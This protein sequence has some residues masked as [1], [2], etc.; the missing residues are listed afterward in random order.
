M[1]NKLNNGAEISRSTN[2]LNSIIM[3][4]IIILAVFLAALTAGNA[5][6]QGQG[7]F[8]VRAG[9][10]STNMILRGNGVSVKANK[11]TGFQ[12]G[13]VT[14]NEPPENKRIFTQ[15]GFLFVSQKCSFDESFLGSTNGTISLS[16]LRMPFN[17]IFKVDLSS[18]KLLGYG[19]GILGLALAG[20][21]TSEER[22]G[23][24]IEQKI[25][26]GGPI[27]R[28]EIGFNLGAGLQFGNFQATVEYNI[29]LNYGVLFN[30]TNGVSMFN[31]GFLFN[32]TYF[33][34]K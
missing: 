34:G 25:K 12:I 31:N 14:E 29:N 18:L 10:N 9:L 2:I 20:K 32:L 7:T 19:G 30:D 5:Q 28:L 6:G 21:T 11:E 24:K 22:G 13:V 15:G 1:S 4:K 33:F 3:N 8:G 27:G 17:S 23:E 26:F 16:Y